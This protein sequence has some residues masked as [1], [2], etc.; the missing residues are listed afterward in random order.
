M[1][2]CRAVDENNEREIKERVRPF[3]LNGP[4]AKGIDMTLPKSIFAAAIAVVL[5][6]GSGTNLGA[7]DIPMVPAPVAGQ[8]SQP[9][10]TVP[11]GGCP[12]CAAASSQSMGAKSC[13]NCGSH[14]FQH[15]T[16]GPYV[17]NLC[18]GACFGYF[19]TQWRKWD[20]V[21]P[22][23]YQGIGVSDAPKPVAPVLPGI[24]KPATTIP[25]PRPVDT[26][27]MSSNY[28]LPSIPV[29]GNIR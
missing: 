5:A 10:T 7:A 4:F 8:Y 18:P 24:S 9:A 15:H 26:K 11:P 2:A 29:A 27:P 13:P 16:K 25:T 17:V 22:Y 12:T 1:S 6:A 20:D 3:K 14:W 21:C 23:P 28:T 19:Q